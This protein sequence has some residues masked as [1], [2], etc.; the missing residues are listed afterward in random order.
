[1][2]IEQCQCLAP[3]PVLGAATDR[4]IETDKHSKSR[5]SR[6]YHQNAVRRDIWWGSAAVLK[7][8]WD[9]GGGRHKR[10]LLVRLHSHPRP[11]AVHGLLRLDRGERAQAKSSVPPIPRPAPAG[12]NSTGPTIWLMSAKG[13]AII[14]AQ[15]QRVGDSN[16]W[17]AG[18]FP[19]HLETAREVLRRSA[20]RSGAPKE[21][22][23]PGEPT[24]DAQKGQGKKG[25]N[26]P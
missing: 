19:P 24:V 17:L 26:G 8:G 5:Q 4:I 1:M 22:I 7:Y 12:S 11:R 21:G 14:A 25:Y 6:Q 3:F 9:I 10:G 18:S 20:K 2:G 13:R 23:E 16:S 15:Q